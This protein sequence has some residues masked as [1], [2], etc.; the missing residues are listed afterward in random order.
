MGAF[1][2]MLLGAAVMALV[3]SLVSLTGSIRHGGHGC[4]R[5]HH[6]LTAPVLV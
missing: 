5:R 2:W 1:A 4:H 3:L 6:S